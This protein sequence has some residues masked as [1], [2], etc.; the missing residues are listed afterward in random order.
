VGSKNGVARTITWAVKKEGVKMADEDTKP[1]DEE[2]SAPAETPEEPKDESTAESE[3]PAET[4]APAEV[5]EESP[6]ETEPET[7]EPQPSRRESLRI[8]QLLEKLKQQPQPEPKKAQGLDYGAALDADPEV[9]KQLETDRQTAVDNARQDSVK[10]A[11]SIQ[12]RTMLEIDAPKIETKYPQLDKESTSF[13]PAV[14]NAINQWY[15]NTAGYNPEN[16]TVQNANVRYGEFVE[17]IMELADEMAGE[18][19]ASSTKNIAKQAAA[20]GLRPDG[21]RTK[22]LDLTKSP[23]I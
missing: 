18:K 19:T 17:G 10:L 23:K 8:Q 4:E 11:E 6:E 21:S 22:G 9:I 16:G 7:E 3:T 1:K 13:S 5:E 14:A 20:T 2:V 12:F 15:L